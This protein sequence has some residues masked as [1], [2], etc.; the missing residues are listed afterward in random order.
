MYEIKDFIYTHDKFLPKEFCNQSILYFENCHKA[1]FTYARN[2]PSHDISDMSICSPE[3]FYDGS[4]GYQADF[5]DQTMEMASTFISNFWNVAYKNYVSKFS[6]IEAAREHSIRSLKI[7]KTVPGQA[8]HGWHWETM[9]RDVGVY[10]RLLT[11]I[12][13]LNDIDDGGETEFLYYP[14]RVKP[15]TG[16][17]ILFPGSFTHTH[18]GNQPLSGEKYIVT[19]WVHY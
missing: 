5:Y 1:G 18:R 7:Q 4:H 9:S 14:T 13:Y 15:K 17:L 16:R 2:S 8:Y 6:I 11:F 3:F 19:G 10:D 12:L